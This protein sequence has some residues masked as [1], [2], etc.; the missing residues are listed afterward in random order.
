MRIGIIATVLSGFLFP[1]Q[2][3]AEQYKL[4]FSATVNGYRSVDKDFKVVDLPSAIGIGDTISV[5]AIFD[6]STY[7]VQSLY[8]ADPTVNIYYGH[9]SDGK[10]QIGNY[11]YTTPVGT[12]DFSSAQ[13]WDNR[14]VSSVSPSVDSFGI[15]S[16]VDTNGSPLPLD[17]GAG[18]IRLS[19]DLMNF[20]FTATA[21]TNDLITQI[22]PL[23]M[24]ERFSTVMNR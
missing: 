1:V 12:T 18:P 16:F 9:L 14:F 17:L 20:D 3:N 11:N 21:R 8:D 22:T 19:L 4:T 24:L 2:A 10:Y 7:V 23:E 6:P 5:S 15:T 13:L